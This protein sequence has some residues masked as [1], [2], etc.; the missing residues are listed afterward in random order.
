MIRVGDDGLT[1]NRNSIGQLRANT[2][3]SN[4]NYDF[5]LSRF[6]PLTLKILPTTET[7]H[8]TRKIVHFGTSYIDDDDHLNSPMQF[9]TPAVIKVAAK[10]A[11]PDLF[12]TQHRQESGHNMNVNR[13][14]LRT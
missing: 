8:D 13:K 7:H 5:H 11:P 6:N 4:S 2:T 3:R 1:A 10:I 12:T 14:V 9:R